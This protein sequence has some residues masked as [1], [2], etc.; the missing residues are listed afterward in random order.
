MDKV[1]STVKVETAPV[2][3]IFFNRPKTLSKIF[4][5]VKK[6][7]PKILLLYQDGPRAGK[8]E[9]DKIKECREIVNNVDW[10]C[11]VYKYY[12][13][14]NIGCDP[15]EY[16]AQ[17]WAFSIVDKCIILEDDDLPSLSFFTYCTLLLD[18]YEFSN[19]IS[20]ISG[21]NHEEQTK[22]SEDYLFTKNCSIWGWATW[23]RV[24]DNWDTNYTEFLELGRKKFSKK[25]SKCFPMKILCDAIEN[26][27]KSKKEHYES[28]LI[29]NSL[30]NNQLT[31][32]PRLNL[33]VN[34]GNNPEGGTHSST[35]I[36]YLP[37]RIQKLFLMNNYEL[38]VLNHPSAIR[39]NKKYSRKVFSIMG[40][41]CSIKKY[42]RKIEVFL[43]KTWKK[44]FCR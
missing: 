12:Q 1:I 17:K 43:R 15:S 6:A 24:V 38:E 21:M 32:V 26:H 35:S 34:I 36:D 39:E 20:I 27:I 7:K 19:E 23:K 2:L 16:I 40:W 8:S 44:L 42:S 30:V 31:I 3:L 9:E 29:Y 5:Q 22:I 37:K 18:K 33:I 28:I 13:E 11:T 25:Y 10:E 41:N 14:K 4:E